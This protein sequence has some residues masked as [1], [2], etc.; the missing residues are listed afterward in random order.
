MPRNFPTKENCKN[1]HKYYDQVK[2]CRFCKRLY[3]TDIGHST[4]ASACPI[5]ENK[6]KKGELIYEEVHSKK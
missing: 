4:I 2:T 5:C 6:I 3:G 1:L